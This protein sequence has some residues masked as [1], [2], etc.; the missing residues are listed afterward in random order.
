MA[1]VYIQVTNMNEAELLESMNLTVANSLAAYAIY[2][3]LGTSYVIAAQIAG[4]TLDRSQVL[5]VTFLYSVSMVVMLFTLHGH[6]ALSDSLRAEQ[7][8]RFPRGGGIDIQVAPITLIS[9][10]LL[11]LGTLK[12]MW[13]VRKKGER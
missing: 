8:A 1:A 11:Y 3:S 6:I 7:L 13:D 2:L 12:Y 10:I 9:S 4:R 5:L